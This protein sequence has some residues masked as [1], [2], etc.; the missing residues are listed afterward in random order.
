[1]TL[2]SNG[3]RFEKFSPILKEIL[4]GIIDKMAI[5]IENEAFSD[6][7]TLLKQSIAEKVK[8][9]EK[10]ANM[11]RM[12]MKYIDNDSDIENVQQTIK[13]LEQTTQNLR[14]RIK[15]IDNKEEVKQIDNTFFNDTKT[16]PA[17]IKVTFPDETVFF[18]HNATETY[19]KTLQEIGLGKIKNLGIM[20]KG[21]SLVGDKKHQT[22]GQRRISSKIF[23]MTSIGTEDKIKY[24]KIIPDA[25]NLDLIIEKIG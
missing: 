20:I 18:E 15:P 23:V 4:Q 24:L 17:R 19:I 10:T 16:A 7:Q 12:S 1:M 11:L 2:V 5:S 6:G 3:R 8:N 22:Y 9:L 14:V 25:F 21:V 13:N